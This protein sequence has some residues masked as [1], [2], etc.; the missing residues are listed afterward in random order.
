M[1]RR[2]NLTF[3]AWDPLANKIIASDTDSSNCIRKLISESDG[4]RETASTDARYH[5]HLHAV[6]IA[7]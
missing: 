7:R 4:D 1:I 6:T 2:A 3:S 5:V